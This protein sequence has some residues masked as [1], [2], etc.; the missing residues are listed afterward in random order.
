M[1]DGGRLEDLFLSQPPPLTSAGEEDSPWDRE[2]L[3]ARREL[4]LNRQHKTK[5]TGKGTEEEAP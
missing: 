3:S 4:R 5:G 1:A 2:V